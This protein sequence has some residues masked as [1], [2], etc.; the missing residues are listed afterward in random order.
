MTRQKVLLKEIQV[1]DSYR[2]SDFDMAL[3]LDIKANGLL[4]PLRVEKQNNGA[5]ILVE[6]Y[7]RYAALIHIN[8]PTAECTIDTETSKSIRIIKRLKSELHH[9]KRT[10]YELHQMIKDLKE[11]E[12]EVKEIVRLCNVT[13]ATIKKYLKGSNVD[14]EWLNECEKAGA[15]I[16][17]AIDIVKMGHLKGENLDYLKGLYTDRK[18][19]GE[20]VKKINKHTKNATFRN[21]TAEGQRDSLDEIINSMKDNQKSNEVIYE[22]S[23][24]ESYTQ[25]V[26]QYV[27]HFVDKLLDRLLAIF[28]GNFTKHLSVRNRN[29]LY[30]KLVLLVE[31]LGMPIK[32]AEFPPGF[33][34][35]DQD[36]DRDHLSH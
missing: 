30:K 13:P 19:T 17:G 25:S 26:H 16:Q 34:K 5:L 10:G 3:A 1:E 23:L 28:I 15:G 4:V 18:I 7:R 20:D 33:L 12:V 32:W 11:Q 29:N 31:R 9:K 27:Y 2:K 6:G 21:L 22:K 8:Q 35:K 36:T 24:K 14:Q